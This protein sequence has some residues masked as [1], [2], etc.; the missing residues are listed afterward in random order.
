M[1]KKLYVSLVIPVF[2][3]ESTIIKQLNE[4]KKVLQKS[5]DKY[6]ILVCDDKS[7][8]STRKKIE[9]Y[10]KFD[11]Q[12]D[13]IFHSENQGIAKTVFSL[14]SKAHYEYIVLYSA[15]GDWQTLDIE[16]LIIS[17]IDQNADMV[18]G[19]RKNKNYTLYRHFVSFFYNFLPILLFGVTTYD[20]GSIKIFKK[21]LFEKCNFTSKSVFFEAEMIIR[22]TKKGYKIATIPV[23]YK[24]VS[25]KTGGGGKLSLVFASLKDIIVLRMQTL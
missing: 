3:N 2:N 19:K 14:Y 25:D 16:K 20:A 17:I 1:K 11:K 9:K 7:T 6:E 23:W 12:I 24:R 5:A 8:D 22:A 21:S 18:I 4:A 13:L 15:D 10:F